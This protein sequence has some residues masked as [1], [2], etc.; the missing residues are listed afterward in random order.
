MWRRIGQKHSAGLNIKTPRCCNPWTLN[1][2]HQG[3]GV[4]CRKTWLGTLFPSL[5]Y[6]ELTHVP[7]IHSFHTCTIVHKGTKLTVIHWDMLYT[8]T[9]L[10][11]RKRTHRHTSRQREKCKL[12][13]SHRSVKIWGDCLI[14]APPDF[15]QECAYT[16]QG[17]LYVA[18]GLFLQGLLPPT[19]PSPSMNSRWT[20]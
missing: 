13:T 20:R 12:T 15:H 17:E 14:P 16:Q 11:W 18:L 9:C 1:E 10:F 2:C 4:L 3:F 6:S 7:N 19:H 5:T 8:R